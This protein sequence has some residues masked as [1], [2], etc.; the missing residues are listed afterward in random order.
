VL[1]LLQWGEP[2]RPW[3][4]KSPAHVLS[5][6]ALD[7]VFPEARFV[8]THRDPTDVMVSVCDVYAD[9][10]GVFTDEMDREYVGRLNVGQWST[11]ME[12]VLA[13]RDG[14]ADDRFYDIDFRAMQAD[15]IGEVRGLYAWLGEPVSDA[16]ESGMR[17]WW[18]E[19]AENR[20]P[21]VKAS[22][23]SFGLDL[24]EV[25]PKFA[26]Y[27]EHVARWTAHS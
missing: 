19:N 5:L 17:R 1:K 11:G 4:L 9:L 6:D 16:F 25:R 26:D 8:M 15:P 24:D 14:G 13:F 2:P 18:E 21:S 3:R 23:E 22:P 12:R 7:R 10:I 20:E 27:V